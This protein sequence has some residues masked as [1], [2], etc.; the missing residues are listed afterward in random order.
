MR[1]T[2]VAVALAGLF[3]ASTALAQDDGG[4]RVQV[5]GQIDDAPMNV[6]GVQ[7]HGGLALAGGAQFAPGVALKYERALSD[8]M[9]LAVQPALHF[10]GAGAVGFGLDLDLRF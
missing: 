4:G 3:S 10:R 6:V 7:F 5:V 2:L 1:R 9:S 8:M